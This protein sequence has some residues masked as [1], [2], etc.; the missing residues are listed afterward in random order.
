MSTAADSRPGPGGP[1]AG[2]RILEF[3]GLGPAPFACMLLSDMGAEIVRIDRAG[4][5]RPDARHA[6][7]R[8]RRSLLEL[9]LKTPADRDMAIELSA[10]ADAA[11]EGFRPGV[12]ERLGLGP[13]ILMRRNPRLV[14]GRMTGWGQ[15]G[16][17]A[18]KAGHDI[19]YIS[20]SGALAAIGPPG[21]K[22][23]PPLNLVG[24]FGG[25]AL[26]LV[27]GV[28]AALLEARRSGLGQ[29]V[30]AAICDGVSSMMA[31][32]MWFTQCQIFGHTE[33]RGVNVIDGG[34]HW[35]TTYV[36]KDGECVAI[37]AFEPQFYKSFVER[38]GLTDPIFAEQHA[39]PDT[40]RIQ[41]ER[42]AA[43]FRT[44]TRAEWCEIFED[45]D[46]CFTPILRMSEAPA[47]PHNIARDQ[48]V[49]VAGVRQPAPA[50]RFSRTP[51]AI[52][53]VSPVQPRDAADVLADWK[54]ATDR[55][56]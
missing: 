35:N 46:A 6:L 23:V 41:L 40:A 26:Y 5:P 33:E 12:M 42:A 24:D 43:V 52:Q 9:D 21:G 20:L 28:L 37:G 30:D 8:G 3:A 19:N 27:V 50:P 10:C 29:V 36:C 54:A 51:A 38:A 4:A 53:G 22:P 47:H 44:R 39:D 16:P 15:S 17:L 31:M 55:P 32:Q 56:T 18:Q 1:L 14:V 11:I 13:E 2:F 45:A 49:D 25:G 7:E 48:F 34:R